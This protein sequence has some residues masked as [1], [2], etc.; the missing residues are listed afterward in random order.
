MSQ[1]GKDILLEKFLARTLSDADKTAFEDLVRRDKSFAQEVALRLAEADAFHRAR[2]ANKTDVRRR[3]RQRRWLR[4]A[5]WGGLGLLGLFGAIKRCGSGNEPKSDK[6]GK[7]EAPVER[8]QAGN[9]TAPDDS[10][11]TTTDSSAAVAR[12][13]APPDTGPQPTVSKRPALRSKAYYAQ[14]ARAAYSPLKKVRTAGESTQP[15]PITNEHELAFQGYLDKDSAIVYAYYDRYPDERRAIEWKARYLFEQGRFAEAASLFA[16]LKT[17]KKYE[18][19][20]AWNELLCYAAQYRTK[21]KDF[22]RLE[23]EVRKT[24]YKGELD[25]L[26]KQIR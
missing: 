4:W 10:L 15:A 21:K 14:I 19:I 1:D 24:K 8:E 3:Y 20:G 18:D 6:D 7:I 22:D 13:G 16:R 12:T 23:K 25:I 5:V 26:L 9:G 17:F 11:P 2:V